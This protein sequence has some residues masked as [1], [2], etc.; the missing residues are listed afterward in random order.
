MNGYAD[1]SRAYAENSVLSAPPERLVVMLYDG[2]A[3]FLAQAVAALESGD[4]P[5]AAEPLRRTH[6]ILDE[7]LGTL[8]LEA[9]EVA[10]R[11]QSIYFFCKRTLVEAQ[12]GREAEPVERV[13][14]LLAVLRGAWAEIATG[15]QA[16][17]AASVGGVA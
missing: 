7:L 1:A 17:G 13:A 6:A 2:A 4:A 11:L 5:A 8:D 10:D 9:G 16:A 15:R 12:L 14:S 3:R